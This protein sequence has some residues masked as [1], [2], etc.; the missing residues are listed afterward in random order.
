MHRA[1]DESRA[2]DACPL[3]FQAAMKGQSNQPD[4]WSFICRTCGIFRITQELLDFL[5]VSASRKETHLYKL[6]YEYRNASEELM[7][8]AQAPVQTIPDAKVILQNSDPTVEAKQKRLLSILARAST[9]PGQTVYLDHAVDYPLLYAK[10]SDEAEFFIKALSD[11]GLIENSQY[12]LDAKG[13]TCKVT[14]TGW[15]EVEKIKQSGKDSADAFIAMWFSEERA[16]HHVAIATAIRNTGYS[17]IRI[18]RIEHVN[19]IDD[20]II[21]RIRRSRFLVADFTGQRN[22]IY[23]EAGFMLG[24]GR[25]VIWACEKSDLSNVHFDTRQYNTIDYLDTNDLRQRLENRIEAI[26]GKGPLEVAMKSRT[27]LPKTVV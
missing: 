3:C 21:A 24:L 22:G 20:E 10:N 7:Q 1:F 12:T 13:S 5:N 26:I 27:A 4:V 16:E 9:Y 14:T 18:D 2:K 8:P 17:P 23:F 19:K 25:P 15:L 6:T 11:Q